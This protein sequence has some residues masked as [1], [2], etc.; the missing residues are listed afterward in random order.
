MRDAEAWAAAMGKLLRESA[1]SVQMARAGV[2][3]L[4]RD[5]TKEKWLGRIEAI[6]EEVLKGKISHR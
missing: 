6:Y 4:Q 1:R 2:A 5:F 3:K